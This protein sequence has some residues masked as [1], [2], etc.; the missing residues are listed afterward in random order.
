M[1]PFVIGCGIAVG[2][3]ALWLF[4]DTVIMGLGDQT[5]WLY[6]RSIIAR[7]A[8]KGIEKVGDEEE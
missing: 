1:S 3:L 6:R 4:I 2:L 7:L 5:T 8:F